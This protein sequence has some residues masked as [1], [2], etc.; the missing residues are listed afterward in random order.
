M[1]LHCIHERLAADFTCFYSIYSIPSPDKQF[2]SYIYA[3]YV[4]H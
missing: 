1:V 2:F 3:S 4:E